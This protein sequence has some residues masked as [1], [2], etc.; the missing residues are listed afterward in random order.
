M[1]TPERE[2]RAILYL[3]HYQIYSGVFDIIKKN[4]LHKGFMYIYDRVIYIYIKG[5]FSHYYAALVRIH[6]ASGSKENATDL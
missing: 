2:V 6:R 4:L 5:K 3:V 1:Y